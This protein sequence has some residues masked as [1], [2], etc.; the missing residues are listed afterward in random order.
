MPNYTTRGSMPDSLRDKIDAVLRVYFHSAVRPSYRQ[1]ATEINAKFSV[2]TYQVQLDGE[3]IR[4][5]F[6]RWRGKNHK[7]VEPLS[8]A[9]D[10]DEVEALRTRVAELEALRPTGDQERTIANLRARLAANERTLHEAQKDQTIT[11]TVREA[12]LEVASAFPPLPTVYIPS[13]VEKTH[14]QEAVL[15]LC[16][17]H[18]GEVV[19]A[20]ETNGFGEYNMAIAQA[21]VQ[22]VV[23]SVIDLVHDHHRGEHI[24]KLWI[25]DLGDNISGDIHE[26]LSITNE[27]PVI[28]QTLAAAFLLALGIRDLAANFD[29]VEMIGL[30]GNHGRN[31]K[32]PAHKQ[33]AEDSFD[34]M[35]Y[36]TVALLCA[37]IPNFK[38]TIPASYWT[39]QV[40]NDVPFVFLHGDNL[41][42]WNQLPF[43]GMYR[44]N[45]NMTMMHG[46]RNEYFRYLGIGHF[47]QVGMLPRMG[48]EILMT[49]SLKGPDE[50]SLDVLQ[51]GS[52]P[53][54]LFYGVHHRRGVSFR[55]PVSARDATPEKHN[56]Y[57][58][59]LADVP[60]STMAKRLGLL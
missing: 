3:H 56:R 26:E 22:R 28:T 19:S 45:S 54:Q 36:E 34:R 42:A 59:E 60:L 52:E 47:H 11:Q 13:I 7:V 2:L 29:E 53:E 41:K 39:R 31:R 46:T 44:L 4:D 57:Q 10:A 9:A 50:Y 21:R 6:R 8:L 49:G 14:V 23:D 43:Y 17:L 24:R 5:T 55:Y 12:V 1:I 33:K 37:N 16:C 35:V 48:G 32:K 27:R 15:Q 30:P 38:M 51:T 58:F 40:I 18:M 20:L 25:P